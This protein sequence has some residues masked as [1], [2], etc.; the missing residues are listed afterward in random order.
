MSTSIHG[1]RQS[2]STLY[3]GGLLKTQTL[4]HRFGMGPQSLHFHPVTS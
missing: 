1:L 4:I 3:P 2:F